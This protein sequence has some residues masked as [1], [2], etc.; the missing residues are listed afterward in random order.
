MLLCEE[1]KE[2]YSKANKLNDLLLLPCPP[3]FYSSVFIPTL[4]PGVDVFNM[5]M[6]TGGSIPKSGFVF[7]LVH[8]CIY[9]SPS[10][11]RGSEEVRFG[12]FLYWVLCWITV[13]GT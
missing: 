2:D 6:P 4:F 5:M 11:W 13:Y 10:L 3:C 8:R 9:L 7:F 12:R 1:Q